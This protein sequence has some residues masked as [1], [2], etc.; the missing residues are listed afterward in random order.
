MNIIKHG[1]MRFGNYTINH[2]PHTLK[3]SDRGNISEN[4]IPYGYSVVENTGAGAMVIKGDGAFY[5]ETALQQYLQLRQLYKKGKIDVLSVGGIGSLYACLS[6]LQ[7]QCQ[8]VDNYLEYSFQFTECEG[9]LKENSTAPTEYTLGVN[10]DLWDASLKLNIDIDTLMKLNPN[11]P[12][13]A[14]ISSIRKIKLR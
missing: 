2:N 4:I 6:N 5:G 1:T 13:P 3:I 7:M 11:I 12:S 10:E 14:D 8:S 9:I